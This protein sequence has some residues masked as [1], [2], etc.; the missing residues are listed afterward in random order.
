MLEHLFGSKTR[1]KLLSLLFRNPS[2]DYFVRELTRKVGERINSVRHELANLQ[3]IGLVKSKSRE[4]KR[5]YQMNQSFPLYKEL[6]DL[7]IKATGAP[8]AKLVQRILAMGDVRYA[9]LTASFLGRGKTDSGVDMFIVGNINNDE[10]KR[11]VR[12]LES[13]YDREIK[14]AVMN[15]RDFQ[16]RMQIGDRFVRDMVSGEHTILVDTR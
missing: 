3:K 8:Q 9:I 5:Y 11:F 10:L 15:D 12:K 7:V 2:K 1:V 4:R 16:Y 6:G 14:Y 13:E